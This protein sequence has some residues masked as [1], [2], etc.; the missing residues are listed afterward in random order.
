MRQ[1]CIV[2]FGLIVG[3][4]PVTAVAEVKPGDRFGNWVYSCAALSSGNTVCGIS[5]SIS[6]KETKA[7]VLAVNVRQIGDKGE[8]AMFAAVQLGVSLA[9]GIA[10]KVDEQD[11]QTLTWQ[12]CTAQR[13]CLAAKRLDQETLAALSAAQTLRVAFLPGL[14]AKSLTVGLSV[15]GLADGIKALGSD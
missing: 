10:M 15:D 2:V 9:P 12:N 11:P 3:I 1:I 8:L 4:F 6:H 14:N 13:G 5:Q 7:Q